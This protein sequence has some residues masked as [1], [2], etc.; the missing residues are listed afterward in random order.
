VRTTLRATVLTLMAGSLSAG[1]G[2]RA[3]PLAVVQVCVGEREGRPAETEVLVLQD[4]E[5]V[6]GGSGDTPGQYEFGIRAGTFE[7]LVDGERLTEGEV[8][9]GQSIAFAVG[10]GCPIEP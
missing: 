8:A 10:E 7:V 2:E 3:E 1:C 5:E 9:S 4:G 6:A